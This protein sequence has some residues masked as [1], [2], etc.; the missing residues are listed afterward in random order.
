MLMGSLELRSKLPLPRDKHGTANGPIVGY[1]DKNIRACTFL[2]FGALSGNGYVNG[3][4]SRAMIGGSVGLGLRIH[5]P[6]LG[7]VRLDYGFP[8]IATALG[9]MTPRFSLG[10][11]DKF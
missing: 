1:L 11:G 8:L 7:V 3:A 4:Y 9:H 2:D 6:M 5:M 10:F